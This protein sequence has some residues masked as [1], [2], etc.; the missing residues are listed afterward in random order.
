MN[1][2]EEKDSEEDW[3]ILILT[4]YL[5]RA[6]IG[7]RV[8]AR[9]GPTI[10]AGYDLVRPCRGSGRRTALSLL[11]TLRQGL[12]RRNLYSYLYLFDVTNND[13]SFDQSLLLLI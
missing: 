13:P 10:G 2:K 12:R 11:F 9:V 4:T 5:G 8:R 3:I 1:W 6:S 7:C